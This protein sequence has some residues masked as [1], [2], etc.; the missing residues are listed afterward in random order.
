MSRVLVTGANGFV[1]SHLCGALTRAGHEVIAAVRDH[2]RRVA[3][4][5]PV[6]VGELNADT[7]WSAALAGVDTVIHTAARVHQLADSQANAAQYFIVNVD[8]TLQL[9]RAAARGGARRLVFLSS[10]KVN[11]E[12][13]IDR[14]YTAS[15]EP[16]PLDAYGESK[17]KAERELLAL[18]RSSGLEVSIVRTPLVYGPGV[19]ANF[20]RLMG[21]IHAGRPLPFGRID[22]RRSLMGVENLCDLLIVA[23]GHPSAANRVFL[24]ADAHLSTRELATKIGDALGRSARLLPVP[25]AALRLLGGLTGRREEIARLCDSLVV[26]VGDTRAILDWSPPATLEQQLARTAQ[27]FRAQ[28]IGRGD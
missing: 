5:R 2:T 25:V 9:A 22:N 10:I 19:R 17:W 12:R 16:H 24:A 13:T 14:A 15:D 1:G 27:W 26:D 6:V 20:L 3:S 7:D 8:A 23:A 4:G 18:A 11:G 21:W 28:V